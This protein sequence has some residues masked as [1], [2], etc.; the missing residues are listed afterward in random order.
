MEE[1]QCVC[2]I[3]LILFHLICE[4]ERLSIT[5][6]NLF[7][8]LIFVLSEKKGTRNLDFGST[9]NNVRTIS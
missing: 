9:V 7:L 6:F 5:Y 8:K 1:K 2:A 4:S 3:I